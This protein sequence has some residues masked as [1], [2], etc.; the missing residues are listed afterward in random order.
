MKRLA[1]A[2][3]LLDQGRSAAA[4]IDWRQ[5]PPLPDPQGFASP[6]A[7]VAGGALILAGGA[8]FSD[9]QIWDGGA[10]VWHDRIF[11]LEPGHDEWR[12]VG[13]LPSPLAYGVSATFGDGVVCVGGSDEKR[14]YAEAFV[15]GYEKGAVV[16]RRLPELPLPVALAA[17]AIAGEVIYIAGGL[18][19]PG[20][21]EALGSF[22]ALDLKNPAA[23]W[24]TL[25]SWPGPGRFQP[26]AAS[27][28]GYFYLCSGLRYETSADN[29]KSLVYLKDAFRYSPAKGWE[30]LADLPH[31]AA[32]AASPAPAG[33][34]GV[35]IIGGVDGRGAGQSPRDFVQ[36]PQRIQAYDPAAAVWRDAGR[37]PVGRVCISTAFWEKRWVLPS[38][39]RSPGI[40]SP[41]VWSLRLP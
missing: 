35:F 19:E 25:P 31:A 2:V 6:F 33:P 21:R 32:A 16:R 38:G 29:G 39:E 36:V 34:S 27:A 13:R 17:G 1:A 41:E 37:A 40:R 4:E 11:A 7:G 12:V 18:S 5:L 20:S 14:H 10:K 24:E 30:K 26:V 23:G 3:L 28:D 15:L 22:F 9:R 8:N